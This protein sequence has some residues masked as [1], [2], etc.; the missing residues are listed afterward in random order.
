MKNEYPLLDQITLPADLREFEA[1]QLPQVADELR[2]CLIE[3]I[4][5]CG[6]HFGSGLGTV[7]LTVALHCLGCRTPSLSPQNSDWTQRT[8]DHHQTKRRSGTVSEKN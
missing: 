5:E 4:A 3:K 1:H 6:G 8:T 2:A 7:E